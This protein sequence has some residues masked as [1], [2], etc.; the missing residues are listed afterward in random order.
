MSNMGMIAH[1]GT[2][3]RWWGPAGVHPVG[4]FAVFGAVVLAA[5]VL[6]A[7]SFP[8]VRADPVIDHQATTVEER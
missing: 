6:A 3:A 7:A 2:Q 5:M 4:L 8:G 1:Q